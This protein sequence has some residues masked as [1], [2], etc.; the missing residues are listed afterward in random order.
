M[1]T[2]TYGIF[3]EDSAIKIFVENAIPQ[4]VSHFGFDNKVAFNHN[5]DYSY[6]IRAT[7][8]S[9][10]ISDFIGAV[11]FGVKNC[12]LELCFVG[13]DSDE[14]EHAD[15]F[16]KMK[17]QL[18][19]SEVESMVVI[20]IPVQAVEFWLWYNKIKQEKPDAVKTA[21]IDRTITRK[22]M[23]QRI[24]NRMKPSNS[25]SDPIARAL[26]QDMDFPWLIAHSESFKHFYDLFH[27]YLVTNFSMDK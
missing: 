14:E 7:S 6:Y 3:A 17:V 26:S 11:S 19:G 5:P 13:L 20:F 15:V 21:I 22:E 23:K 24:Y 18:I 10:I 16:E 4:L 9:Y 27:D 12:N 8:R 1:K 2:I 25:K